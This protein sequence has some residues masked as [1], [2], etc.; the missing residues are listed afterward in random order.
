MQYVSRDALH[1][2]QRVGDRPLEQTERG[3]RAT[4]SIR[5]T[6]HAR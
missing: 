1:G 2:A 4:L 3:T 6:S 5:V